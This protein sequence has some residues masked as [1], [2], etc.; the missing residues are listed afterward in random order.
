MNIVTNTALIVI[1]NAIGGIVKYQTK[2]S[3]ELIPYLLAVIG[4]ILGIALHII[5]VNIGGLNVLEDCAIGVV[6]G[7]ASVGV[8]QLSKIN[9]E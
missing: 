8:H 2:L 1:C 6:S 3:N 5:G 7:F 4:G 9:K